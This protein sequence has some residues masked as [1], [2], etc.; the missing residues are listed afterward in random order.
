MTLVVVVVSQ[1]V[2]AAFIGGA[3]IWA[4][5]Q[6]GKRHAALVKQRQFEQ[7]YGN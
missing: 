5:R 6:E 7:R 4:E 2:S 1:A 3:I